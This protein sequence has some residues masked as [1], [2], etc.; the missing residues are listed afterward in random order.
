[1]NHILSRERAE[2]VIVGAGHNSLVAAC[3]LARAG[4]DVLVLE[5]APYL[6]GAAVSRKV[7]PGVDARVSRYAYLVSLFP[8]WLMDDLGVQIPLVR[9]HTSS[10]TPDP[11]NPARGLVVPSDSS[12]PQA[13]ADLQDRMRDLTG[14]PEDADA[15]SSFYGHIGEFAPDLFA[16]LTEPLRPASAVHGMVGDRAWDDFFA[17]PLGAVLDRTFRDDV[18]RGVVL[19]DALIGT[20]AR[21]DDPSLRQNAC[22]LYHVIGNGTGAWDLPVGGMGAVTDALAERAKGLGVQVHTGVRVVAVS[23]DGT[24]AS[25]AAVSADG[26]RVELVADMVLAG[27]APAE[28]DRLMRRG[29]ADGQSRQPWQ[30]GA[31]IKVNMVL[32]RLP[33][34]RDP[35]VDPSQAFG[36]TLHVN[37][38]ASQLDSAYAQGSR[39]LLPEPVPCE[40]YCH[41]LGDRSILGP[42]LARSTAQTLTVFA[43]QTPHSLFRGS[44]A[45]VAAEQ[46]KAAVLA[47][48]NRVLAEP[49]EDC[50]LV[51]ANGDACIEVSTTADLERDLGLPGGNIFHTPLD[52]PF[53]V[54]EQETG[55]W[56]VETAWPNIA[57]CGSGA[58]RGGGVSGIPGHNAAR[59]ALSVLARNSS[60]R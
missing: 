29:T 5:A 38:T 35:D 13:R 23:S 56:G 21:S 2:V 43:L 48:L 52:M 22:F 58:R 19:T 27:C 24:R 9:R 41:S 54:N 6:G 60:T 3:L 18:V 34:L 47:S 11:R 44:P 53:A 39:G 31:Q 36:G 59:Y 15:W 30:D 10:Y 14:S 7:F 51:D 32:S 33:E 12:G 4:R 37:E 17:Q 16:T 55:T 40:A 49:I 28:L 57:V 26:H 25:V 20:F 8:Q 1:M 50:L 46:A 45:V 42:E